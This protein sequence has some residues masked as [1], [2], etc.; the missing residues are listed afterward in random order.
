MNKKL[1]FTIAAGLCLSS[2]MATTPQNLNKVSKVN[3]NHYSK[4]M[5]AQDDYSLQSYNL[6]PNAASAMQMPIGPITLVDMGSSP[7]LYTALVS[8][9]HALTADQNLNM[10][11]YNRRRNKNDFG[12]S[13]FIQ[14]SFSLNNG[15]SFDST[16]T[17]MGD[18]SDSHLGRYP[19]GAILNPI[20]N[21][22]PLE[23]F[24]VSSGPWHPGA[25]WQGNFFASRKANGNNYSAYFQDNFA[26]LSGEVISDF[27][28]ISSQSSDDETYHVMGGSFLDANGTTAAAQ[29]YNFAVLHTGKLNNTT[30]SLDWSSREF[31]HPFRLDPADLSKSVFTVAHCAWSQDGSVGYVVYIGQD[32]ANYDQIQAFQPIVY[33]TTDFGANWNLMPVQNYSN[34]VALKKVLKS[35]RQGTKRAFFGSTHGISTTV[36]INNDLHIVAGIRSASTDQIDSLDF[37]WNFPIII[38]DV[39]TNGNTWESVIIDS[40]LT[41][42]V[43]DA[44]SQWQPNDG[45]AGNGWDARIQVSRTQDGKKIFYGWM[46][47]DDTWGSGITTNLFPDIYAKGYDVQTKLATPTINFTSSDAA[48]H[49]KMQWMFMQT[50]T[51]KNATEYNLGF[52]HIT[53]YD[54]SFD[55]LGAIKHW[56][57]KGI[58]FNDTSFSISASCGAFG[59]SNFNVSYPTDTASTNGSVTAELTGGTAP[60]TYSWSTNPPQTTATAVGLGNQTYTLTV[61]DATGCSSSETVN[62][63]TTTVKEIQSSKFAQVYPNPTLGLVNIVTD[64]SINTNISVSV[65]AIDGS[66]VLNKNFDASVT[67]TLDLSSVS[68][69]LYFVK[70]TA[71]NKT[72]I[73]KITKM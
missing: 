7:N 18:S 4:L 35:T 12:N 66:V 32:S 29:G 73:V 16:L 46:D 45:S 5:R 70:V 41:E 27:A 15:T 39:K 60:F 54:G 72:N 64:K 58:A 10:I 21:T 51:L 69:G 2:L 14:T 3:K 59:I 67:K 47:T 8:E 42:E 71:G 43:L 31:P 65:V 34:L 6:N 11:A 36:D 25:S 37:T 20:G 26:L 24:L 50:I 63:S 30:N 17:V 19:T 62:L 33:K 1:L 48:L 68:K 40:L 9:S 23:A 28:R 44:D 38:T 57:V 49:G 55:A 53:S 56:Y 22:N 61:T 13:G 52:S